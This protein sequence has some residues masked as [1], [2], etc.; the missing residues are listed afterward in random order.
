MPVVGLLG[1]TSLDNNA[2]RLR[3]FRQG[4]K[5]IGYVDGETVGRKVNMSGCRLWQSTSFANRS[6]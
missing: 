3:A 4:L 6:P 2:D 5:E 1:A